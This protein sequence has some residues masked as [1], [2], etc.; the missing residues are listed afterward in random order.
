M[1]HLIL[2]YHYATHRTPLRPGRSR[3]NAFDADRNNPRPA[4]RVVVLGDQRGCRWL[5]SVNFTDFGES[6]HP[7]ADGH[8][9]AH[10]PVFS[11]YAG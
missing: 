4:G 1:S 2:T 9:Q 6:Y 5:H 7:T 8:S 3:P 10:L 11:E